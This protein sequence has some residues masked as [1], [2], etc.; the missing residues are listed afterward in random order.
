LLDPS[1]DLGAS[2]E[3]G[4]DFIGWRQTKRRIERVI[5]VAGVRAD[6]AV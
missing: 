6:D 2:T 4:A 3:H 5:G 1:V